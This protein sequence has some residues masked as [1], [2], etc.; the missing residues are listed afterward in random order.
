[1]LRRNMTA[2]PGGTVALFNR[3]LWAMRRRIE[4]AT[5]LRP[6][7]RLAD[8]R[9]VDAVAVWGARQSGWLARRVARRRG[10]RC[11]VLEDGFLRSL[12]PGRQWRG[13]GLIA[14]AEGI[15][16]DTAAPGRLAR[17][18]DR[19]AID[20]GAGGD[21]RKVLRAGRLSKY[22]PPPTPVPRN[23]FHPDPTRNVVVVDQRP[24]DAA[25]GGMRR[26]V[27]VRMLQAAACDHPDARV[28]IRAHPDG[29]CGGHFSARALASAAASCSATAEA[30]RSG[31]VRWLA[32]SV[33]PYDI[34]DR[35]AT[36]HVAT[37][38]MGLE[39]LIAGCVTVCHGPAFYAGRG[40]TDDR[41]AV[42]R[43]RPAS[44]NGVLAAAY[45]DHCTWFSPEGDTPVSFFEAA[46]RLRQDSAR[47]MGVPARR[48]G[49]FGFLRAG[50]LRS[51]A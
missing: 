29:R 22:T 31:R 43:L 15:W 51:A 8:A 33:A 44:L 26:D 1:M 39:A 47:G 50:L 35:V 20:P 45:L 46:A 38:L 2:R 37:S 23:V 42:P 41:F 30:L 49:R 40:L 34:F 11:V 28:L 17:L 18:I 19:R 24:G 12:A 13:V 10:L 7:A 14:D 21:V 5:G 9:G 32:P 48:P 3:D 25:L 4:A 6:V 16:Y 27:F 36:V